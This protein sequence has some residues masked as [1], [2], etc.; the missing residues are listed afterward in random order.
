MISYLKYFWFI[1]RNW[2][3]VL[4]AFTVFHE[5]KGEK[6]YGI[7]TIQVN[8][9]QLLDVKGVNKEHASIYQGASYYMLD[10]VF[11]W[12]EAENAE[13]GFVDFGSGKGRVMAVAAHYGYK[14]ITGVEFAPAL[15]E[16]AK[17]NI[18]KI[19]PQ[20]PDTE[21]VFFCDDAVHFTIAPT[22]CVFFFFNPFDEIIL[23]KIVR[24][25]LN[26]L[27]EKERIIYIVY[28]NPMHK[29]ILQSAGFTEE[30]YFRKLIF[31]EMSIF[32]GN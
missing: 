24:K 30:Y 19:K 18:E 6:K 16:Y 22:D 10:R 28:L 32:R 5:M 29:E 23:L 3:P 12:L 31:L 9:L 4:A 14:K 7:D 15:C 27:K 13:G 20:F 25:I 8:D 11:R 17:R 1:T 2:N 26:S 21:F